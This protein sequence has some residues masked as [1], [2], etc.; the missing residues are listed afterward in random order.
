MKIS[1]QSTRARSLFLVPILMIATW[2]ILFAAK[3]SLAA[4]DANSWTREGFVRATKLEP[5]NAVYWY[6]F[7]LYENWNPEHPDLRRAID[8]YRRA[9]R[10][11]RGSDTYWL[12]LADAYDAAGQPD[13]ADSAFRHAATAHPVSADV[14]WRYGNFLLRQQKYPEAFAQIRRAL[15][16]DPNLTVQA[17]SESSRVSDNIS[18]TVS[19][20]L[21]NETKYYVVALDYFVS[22]NQADES[23]AVWSHLRSLKPVVKMPEVVPL[24][25]GLLHEQRAD[26]AFM[27]WNEALALTGWPHDSSSGSS[28]V[29]NGGFEHELLDGGFD[30]HED[31]VSGAIYSSETNTVHTGARAVRVEFDGTTNINFQ[32]LWQF[33]PVEPN[34]RYH[35]TGYLRLDGISS[36]SGVRFLIFDPLHPAALQIQTANL[37]GTQP[38][39]PVEQDVQTLPDTHLLVIALRRAPSWKFDNKLSGT[40]WVDDVS[41]TP[42]QQSSNAGAR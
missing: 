36:D 16:T 23:L 10:A 28:L 17:V 32:H 7:G 5:G 15:A 29:F 39:G 18:G 12:S 41:L 4:L 24:V 2:L 22:Q 26:D 19:Q 9:T 8:D 25:D 34:R 13:Q 1:L 40:V 31:P 14:A 42:F 38:W 11:S 37:T 27:V 3:I 6:H 21:P 30:W 20:I 35:F 33:V